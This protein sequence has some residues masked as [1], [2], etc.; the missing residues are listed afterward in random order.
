M[1]IQL[2]LGTSLELVHKWWRIPAV[3]LGGVIGGRY[4][5]KFNFN[6]HTVYDLSI[7]GIISV[8]A[9][10]LFHSMFDGNTFLVGASGGVFALI[11]A[12]LA[13]II[14]VR[15]FIRKYFEYLLGCS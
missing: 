11:S 8:G 3:Y 13:N 10:C 5:S 4:S 7:N 6:P 9:G 2:L 1:V 12:R 14:L 15:T